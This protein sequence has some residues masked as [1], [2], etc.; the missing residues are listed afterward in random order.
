[1]T[2]PSD[3]YGAGN[4]LKGWNVLTQVKSFKEG[5]GRAELYRK[6]GK[7]YCSEQQA[8]TSGLHENLT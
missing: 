7:K 5:K 1:M 4:L 6:P 2:T 3:E 8:Q